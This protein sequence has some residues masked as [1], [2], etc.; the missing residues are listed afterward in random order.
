M[1][2]FNPWEK[3]EEYGLMME[4][5][6]KGK[7]P[8]M[9]S[10]KQFVNLI[11]KEYELGLKILDVGCNVGH[12]FSALKKLD[13]KI[14]YTGVD[15]ME[16]YIKKAK[17]IFKNDNNSRFFVKNIMNPIYSKNQFDIVFCCNLIL[18]LPNFQEPIKNL[19]DCTSKTCFIR[20]LL[21]KKTTIVKMLKNDLY[22]D[23][24]NP[25][26]Y[27]FLNTWNEDYV[28]EYIK[29]MNCDVEIIND[30]MDPS[31]IQRDYENQHKDEGTRIS[32]KLQVDENIILNWK[33]IKISKK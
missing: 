4:K 5:R 15:F 8:E 1:S 10:T 17:E 33:W 16:S 11:S 26:E 31:A 21:G 22:D 14:D 12:Y 13:S 2:K 9:E 20:T 3:G 32:K 25:L 24:F 18:H 30:E 27:F 28:I 23:T 6:A 7:I 19:V 29:S